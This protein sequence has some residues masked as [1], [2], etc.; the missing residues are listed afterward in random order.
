M[1]VVGRGELEARAWAQIEPLLPV[2]VRGGGGAIMLNG[3]LWK[4]RAGA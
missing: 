3:I 4:L 1:V 2:S